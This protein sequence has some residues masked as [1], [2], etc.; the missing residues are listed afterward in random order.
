MEDHYRFRP[1]ANEHVSIDLLFGVILVD[2][3]QT[4]VSNSYRVYAGRSFVE[5]NIFPSTD[6]TRKGVLAKV[7]TKQALCGPPYRL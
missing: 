2:F 5:R 1:L 6:I 7:R 3:A 4:Y